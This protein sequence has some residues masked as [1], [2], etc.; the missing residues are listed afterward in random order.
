MKIGTKI[1]LGFGSIL[2]LALI[3]GGIAVYAMFQG[4]H[5]AANL[6]HKQVPAVT[7]ANDVE[8]S[9]LE[10]MY[11]IRGYVM[12]DSAKD[13]EEGEK[14]LK[15]VEDH[16][17][18]AIELAKKQNL[19][20]LGQNAEDAN[21]AVVVY[22]D[23]L[24]KTKEKKEQI[25]A[26][27]KNRGAAAV[28][29]SDSIT[30]FIKE[31]DEAFKKELAQVAEGTVTPVALEDRR[32]KIAMANDVIDLGNEIRIAAWQSQAANDPHVFEKVLPNFAAIQE[33]VA[34][35]LPKTR[36]ESNKAQ[37]A[38]TA[39][40]A[41]H[42]KEIAEACLNA[43]K[44]LL[45]IGDKRGAAAAEVVVAAQAA[46]SVNIKATAKAAE[47]TS[48][49][50]SSASL[51]LVIG[52]GLVLALG[53]FLAWLITS[54]IMK[55]LIRIIA[56]MTACAGQTASA[57]EQVAGGAQTLADGTSKTAAA[58]E[59]TSASLEE[60]SSL[61]KQSAASADSANS[62]A[63]QARLAGE[64][65]ASAMDELAKAISEIKGN[66]DQTAKIVKTIDE[67][68]FQTNLLALNA[69]VEAA[70][71]GDAG[72]GFAVV[73]EEVRNLA[74]RAGE[75]A[76]NTSTLIEQSVKS[77]ENGVNLSKN[78]TQVVGEMTVASKKV[79]DLAG[80]VAA[81]AKEIAQGIDQVSTAVRQMDQVTQ[82][83][84]AAAEENSAVG[85]EM[86]AQAQTLSG[87]VTELESMI[88]QVDQAS[89]NLRAQ[90]QHRSQVH[91]QTGTHLPARPKTLTA[92]RMPAKAATG[93]NLQQH[94]SSEGSKAIPFDHEGKSADTLGKF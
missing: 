85:E 4:S 10:T 35:I 64:R 60:M 78:V 34:A 1:T 18:T 82:G 49:Q 16:L 24:R 59:E 63:A 20:K 62:V 12:S 6:E 66:A 87:L 8:R 70:R 11:S 67:I 40:A 28:E 17:K 90:P 41:K 27:V 56:D 22:K 21:K 76:R 7:V 9:S 53:T 13:L 50:L 25:A 15:E 23:L 14:H 46:A 92:E 37:L 94:S 61:V 32:L 93:H 47:E 88:R 29:F 72:K 84:A 44:E 57:S 43:E 31:Q 45:A 54:G 3:L 73:A 42:Y 19:E 83:N 33:K 2:A 80:E 71:A 52:L 55:S 36:L 79:N 74:Q 69:A 48:G 26:A 89:Q 81:S 91:A 86:S 58:L 39:A 75:A 38:K 30:R 77:A 65:G 51:I 5:A 68:A